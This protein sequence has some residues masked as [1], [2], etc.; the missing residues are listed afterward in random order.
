MPA[1]LILLTAL[2]ILAIKNL[3]HTM[4]VIAIDI[5]SDGKPDYSISLQSPG[6]AAWLK[7]GSL[8]REHRLATEQI[9][10]YRARKEGREL[11]TLTLTLRRI[12]KEDYVYFLKYEPK[13]AEPGLKA[14][15]TALGGNPDIKGRQILYTQKISSNTSRWSTFD[16]IPGRPFLPAHKLPKNAL[17]LDSPTHYLRLGLVDVYRPVFNGVR[18]ELFEKSEPVTVTRSGGNIVYTIPLPQETGTY[19]ENWGVLSVSPL[20]DWGNPEAVNDAKTGD[21]ARYR[22]LSADGFYYLTPANYHPT[23]KNYFWRNPAYHVAELFSGRQGN[24]FKD[25]AIS[26]LYSAIETRTPGHY[27]VTQPRSDWLYRDYDIPEGFYD[28]RFSTDAALFLLHMYQKYGDASA[29]RAA[30]DY[31]AWLR[32]YVKDQGIPTM[33]G[34]MLVP[35]YIKPGLNHKKTHVSLNHLVTEMNFL[36]EIYLIEKNTADLNTANLIR[37]AVR[38]TGRNWIRPDYNL[39]Y[40]YINGKYGMQ[41]YPLLTLNDLRLSQRLIKKVSGKDDEVFQMLIEAKEI[42]LRKNNMPLK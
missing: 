17:F 21:L 6:Q 32:K 19:V 20:I 31:A 34:G 23:G 41:D 10:T 1:L 39:H 24:Y 16:V 15:I 26:S 36:Y 40:A 13:E 12:A 27:W 11:G 3:P 38:D 18:A 25:V 22:K 37:Q 33:G 28:T 5:N 9:L 8:K 35:D 4:Q 14:V 7:S 2:G 30:R 29:L 42:Y